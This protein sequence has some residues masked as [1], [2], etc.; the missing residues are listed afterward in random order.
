K[1]HYKGAKIK[2]SAD[3]ANPG[4]VTNVSDSLLC[5]GSG[6]ILQAKG[7]CEGGGT[8]TDNNTTRYPY[9]VDAN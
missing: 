3:T 6:T 2:L 5:L 7:G 9:K 8:I 1:A 4:T